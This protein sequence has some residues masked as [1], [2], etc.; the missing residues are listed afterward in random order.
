MIC[1]LVM[2]LLLCERACM[3]NLHSLYRILIRSITGAYPMLEVRKQQRMEK[4]T[5]I[6]IQFFLC[7][8]RASEQHRG[9]KWSG[10]LVNTANAD[11]NLTFAMV[12]CQRAFHCLIH[13]SKPAASFESVY[14]KGNKIKNITMPVVWMSSVS[15]FISCF[16]FDFGIHFLSAEP[17]IERS[18][19]RIT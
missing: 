1:W 8:F 15:S 4:E 5:H 14:P 6:K 19:V 3:R 17:S 18:L 9:N 11:F 12:L 10:H 2:L 16:T 7:N 13:K